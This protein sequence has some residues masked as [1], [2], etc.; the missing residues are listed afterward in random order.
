EG[1]CESALETKGVGIDSGPCTFEAQHAVERAETEAV[2]RRHLPGHAW[3][4]GVAPR[5][6]PAAGKT[7]RRDLIR[8]A[9]ER[10]RV[11]GRQRQHRR[12][13]VETGGD[14]VLSIK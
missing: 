14:E 3:G 13:P 9:I 11:R 5:F 6:L 4:E 1:V 12:Q 10:E 7:L 8:I 2:Q